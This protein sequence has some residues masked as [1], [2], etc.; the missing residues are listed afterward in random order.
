MLSHGS[1]QEEEED[2]SEGEKALKSKRIVSQLH[3]RNGDM[4][5][6]LIRLL[7][8]HGPLCWPP[9]TPLP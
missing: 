2:E 1:R 5:N 3:L 6:G 8:V 7:T 4:L 9:W